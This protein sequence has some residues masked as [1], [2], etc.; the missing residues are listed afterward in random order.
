MPWTALKASTLWGGVIQTSPLTIQVMV[1]LKDVVQ[2]I[3]IMSMGL[4]ECT[5]VLAPSAA[6]SYLSVPRATLSLVLEKRVICI[7]ADH[8]T[9]IFF[10][11]LRDAATTYF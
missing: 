5:V 4:T 1:H 9:V 3:I 10:F 11:C 2:Y 6:V 7:Q 8:V